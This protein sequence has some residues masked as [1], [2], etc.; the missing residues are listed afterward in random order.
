MTIEWL[1]TLFTN[2][3][4]LKY[5]F[6]L[7]SWIMFCCR[8][9]SRESGRKSEGRGIAAKTKSDASSISLPV[10]RHRPKPLKTRKYKRS[11]RSFKD[12]KTSHLQDTV[13]NRLNTPLS[14]YLH[15]SLGWEICRNHDFPLK[16]LRYFSV[17][18]SGG[19]TDGHCI[20]RAASM[21]KNFISVTCFRSWFLTPHCLF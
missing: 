12:N 17:E 13:D 10:T 15:H 4:L 9:P 1:K 11:A 18:Q 8:D 6:F 20:P 5:S 3:Q 2:S 14:S 21:A 7:K 19:S 16:F